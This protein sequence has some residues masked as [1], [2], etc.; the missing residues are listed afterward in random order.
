MFKLNNMKQTKTY[1]AALVDDVNINARHF[2]AMTEAE[3]VDAMI[4]D[5]ITDDKAW[6]KKAYKES[7]K[8]VADA[9]K[10]KETKAK[11]PAEEPVVVVKQSELGN[12]NEVKEET[13]ETKEKGIG[14]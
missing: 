11:A 6:A 12:K 3:A 2:A 9:D 5:G 14:Q 13:K 10:P 8:K 1:V 4:K 7:V